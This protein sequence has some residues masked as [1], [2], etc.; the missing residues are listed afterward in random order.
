MSSDN[1]VKVNGKQS[2]LDGAS[3]T[4]LATSSTHICRF[5]LFAA[6]DG[7]VP[8]GSNPGLLTRKDVVH[9]S[10]V[11]WLTYE[12]WVTTK[13]STIEHIAPDTDPGSGWDTKIYSD[14]STKHTVGN[15]VPFP[16]NVNSSVGNGPWAKKRLFYTVMAEKSEAQRTK[17]IEEA[18][19]QDVIVPD[20]TI[21]LLNSFGALEMLEHVSRPNEWSRD[22]ILSRT[23]NILDLAWDRISPWLFDPAE[24]ESP[25]GES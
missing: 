19:E 3:G 22:L 2:W 20:A 5:L 8:D 7:S 21:D 24:E 10:Q 16:R 17:L 11:K 9:P 15:L 6:H 1:R 23:A 25:D 4:A 13:Y 14:T 12:N 18:K